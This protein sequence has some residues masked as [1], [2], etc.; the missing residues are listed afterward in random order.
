MSIELPATVEKALRALAVA[1]GRALHEL[2][3]EAVRLYLE[4]AALTAEEVG[5]T[6][7]ALASEL[8]AVKELIRLRRKEELLALQGRLEIEDNCGAML[9]DLKLSADG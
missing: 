7:L 5:E 2:V 9:S 1:Q 6:Q 3:D 8:R 4:A